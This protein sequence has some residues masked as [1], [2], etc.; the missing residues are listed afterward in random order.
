MKQI[1]VSQAECKN[2]E[3]CYK[4]HPKSCKRFNSGNGCK[5]GEE[6]AYYHK[7]DPKVKEVTELK[8]KIDNLEKTVAKVSK[9][10]EKYEQLDKALKAMVRKVLSLESEVLDLKNKKKPSEEESVFKIK[11]NE[12]KEGQK[13]KSRNSNTTAKDRKEVHPQEKN[14]PKSKKENGNPDD[15]KDSNIFNPSI[16]SSPK[17]NKDKQKEVKPKEDVLN[18]GHCDYKTKQKSNSQ[19][20]YHNKS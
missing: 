19:K 17:E 3:Q 16:F 1:C 18:C 10:I 4:R 7:S 8:D 11:E 2:T 15:L 9:E 14:Q 5:H 6:C 13:L 12:R 20:A